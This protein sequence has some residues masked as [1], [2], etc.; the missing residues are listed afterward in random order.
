MRKTETIFFVTGNINKVNEL[1]EMLLGQKG[2][3]VEQIVYDYTEIQA[4]KLED[5]ASYGAKI[6]SIHTKKA[7]I[8]EDSGLFIDALGGFPGPY[9][10]Y[11]FK[12]IG[13]EGILK[14]MADVQNRQ[15]TFRSVIAFYDPDSKK[16]P[17]LFSG[18]VDGVIS[19]RIRGNQG[20]GYDP[21]FCVNE[22]TFGEISLK[23][24]NERSHRR[25]AFEKFLK[26]F[27]GD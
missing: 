27:L 18:S 16:E 3:E 14:L 13:N 20:F 19:D 23:E 21:I 7:I 2:I 10:A 17:I 25:M 8:V 1:K 24:K 6:S 26:W 5:V 9:S 11:V 22:N 12:K 4:D 15:A